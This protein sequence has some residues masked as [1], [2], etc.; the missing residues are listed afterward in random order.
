MNKENDKNIKKNV[1]VIVAVSSSSG[2]KLKF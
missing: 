2:L 1:D